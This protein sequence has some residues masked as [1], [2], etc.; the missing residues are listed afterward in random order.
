MDVWE[1]GETEIPY[2]F[3]RSADPLRRCP[4]RFPGRSAAPCRAARSHC[5]TALYLGWIWLASTICSRAAEDD[6][7]HRLREIDARVIPAESDQA[8]QLPG[9]LRRDVDA[10][11]RAAN[12]RET[13]A[14]NK[15]ATRDDW[16]NFRNGR[17]E[18]LRHSLGQFPPVPEELKVRVTRT[19]N[20]NGCAIEN[21]VFESRPGWVVTANLYRPDTPHESMPGILICHSHHNAK[22]QSELQDMGVTWARLG[23]L[24][25]VMDQ[26]G[27]GERRQHP[28]ADESSF[29][30]PF[31]V[32]RQ[33]YY[34]RYNTGMQLVTIGDSLIGWM[35]WDLCR[36]VDLLL[37]Q[38]AI[39]SERIVLL[40]AVAG[41][42]D[43]AAVAA[44]LDSRIAAVVPFNFGGPQP[45]T[46]YPLPADADGSFNYSGGGSWE[47]TRNLQL[48]ARDGFLPWVIVGSV[49]PRGL[50]YAHEFAWDRERDPVWARLQTVFGF[51]GAVDR[52]SW[53]KGRGSVAGKPP[54][55]THCN[56]IGP[57]HR[58]GIYAA[59]GLW[60][61]IATPEQESSERRPAEELAAMTRETAEALQPRPLWTLAAELGAARVA[62][63]RHALFSLAPEARRVELRRSWTGL[64]GDVEPQ[65]PKVGLEDSYM[66]GDVSVER[67][68]LE[69]ETGI[70]VPCVLL[71]PPK[72]AATRPGVVIAV[73]QHGKQEF[74]R[75]RR[76]EIAGLVD[77]GIAVCLADLRGTG[78]TR[79]DDA[80]GRNS[81]A[82]GISSTELMLGQTLT[83]SRLR[84]LRSVVRYL[85]GRKELDA[86]RLGLWGDSFAP[87][88][89]NDRELA[90]PLD[91]DD[92]LDLAE[93]LGGTLA[94]FGA[95]F[96]DD[97]R[98]VYAR[99][100]LTGYQALLQSPF[101][102]VP[103]DG[104]V[105]AALTAGDLCDVA[106]AL[107]PRPLRLEGLVDGA[108]RP[109][110]AEAVAKAYEPTGQAYRTA[111]A[112][113]RFNV[114][115]R[116]THQ[117]IDAFVIEALSEAGR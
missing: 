83:G 40:G 111:G 68:V 52:L 56:N 19:F 18:R 95:L 99:G 85:R 109:A 78:E 29:P 80:R 2:S 75:Q 117:G 91:A 112:E 34:F 106:A 45:E 96:E 43:P 63:A 77:G 12:R 110:T 42:G 17:V 30:R 113:D 59:L 31:R 84:D 10:R 5:G 69:V 107:A 105:P 55:S 15:V 51:Y 87:V 14:W 74:L 16:E 82:T 20:G 13:E 76:H 1:E 92:F 101:C 6:L 23:C 70:V 9:M 8:K 47:S 4:E 3:P 57:E 88:N 48:S 97:V 39:D 72:E 49:A 98:A 73:A 65:P 66:L 94:L 46:R 116:S 53:V 22:T 33:D 81:S 36:G 41:G 60:F 79:P 32:G 71:L 26:V 114:D 35:V 104:I 89:A 24:V 50:I 102:Y 103:H 7:A 67:L 44:A 54:E 90:V 11:L 115:E 100:G 28:F 21:L 37:D 108:N 38:P 61:G 93:P 64:L 62:A 27:H 86:T 58:Q 25:L